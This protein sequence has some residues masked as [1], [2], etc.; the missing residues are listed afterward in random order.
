MRTTPRGS[1]GGSP[2]KGSGNPSLPPLPLLRPGT[3]TSRAA[4]EQFELLPPASQLLQHSVLS[5]LTSSSTRRTTDLLVDMPSSQPNSSSSHNLIERRERLV[6]SLRRFALLWSRATAA[7]HHT[8]E[9]IRL[10]TNGRRGSPRVRIQHPFVKR[11]DA[12]QKRFALAPKPPARPRPTSLGSPRLQTSERAPPSSRMFGRQG[13][14]HDPSG[15]S[16]EVAALLADCTRA[17]TAAAGGPHR[18]ADHRAWPRAEPPTTTCSSVD[19]ADSTPSGEPPLDTAAFVAAE[20]DDAKRVV[21]EMPRELLL[22]TLALVEAFAPLPALTLTGASRK[23]SRPT[24]TVACDAAAGAPAATA[25]PNTA[26]AAI[27]PR[28]L[29]EAGTAAV[30]HASRTAVNGHEHSDEHARGTLRQ[31]RPMAGSAGLGV[32]VSRSP[33]TP[34]RTPSERWVAWALQPPG[35]TGVSGPPTAIL[36]N[37]NYMLQCLVDFHRLPLPMASDPFCL[38]WFD[39]DVHPEFHPTRMHSP[40]TLRRM[41]AADEALRSMLPPSSMKMLYRAER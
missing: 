40:E 2:R 17:S 36:G 15:D 3:T 18:S 34:Q 25:A 14:S 5:S 31:R 6:G 38:R 32:G 22:C 20:F 29:E 23:P 10:T 8:A 24:S 41:D 27:L 16:D 19:G 35:R 11:L 33:R 12:A 21:A 39:A 1:G 4:R 28:A 7:Q 37:V 13:P 30:A 26:T 9:N